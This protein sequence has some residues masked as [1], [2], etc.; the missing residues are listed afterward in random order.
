R[1]LA[2][3]AQN[4]LD[5]CREVI[6]RLL[7]IH[8]GALV[9]NGDLE[10]GAVLRSVLQRTLP[11]GL[12]H[13]PVYSAMFFSVSKRRTRC[14]RPLGMADSNCFQIATTK[15]SVDGMIPLRK[16]TSRLRFL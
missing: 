1:I 9:V 7:P 3:S 6:R 4:I 8:V 15:F 12:V 2:Y 11:T 14:S 5:A 10:V 13:S 16:S